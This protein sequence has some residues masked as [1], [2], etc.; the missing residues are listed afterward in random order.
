MV[1]CGGLVSGG[2]PD[3]RAELLLALILHLVAV[4]SHK[5]LDAAGGVDQLLLTGVERVAEGAD[6]AVHHIVLNAIDDLGVVR[7][8]GGDAGP[9]MVAIYEDHGIC[10]GMDALLHFKNL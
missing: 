2:T 7:F 1:D 5:L 6:F 9:L 3:S 8:G 4:T 10:C